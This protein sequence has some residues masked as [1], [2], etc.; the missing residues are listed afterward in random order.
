MTFFSSEFGNDED[1]VEVALVCPVAPLGELNKTKDESDVQPSQERVT[2]KKK[3]TWAKMKR[4]FVSETFQCVVALIILI[5]MLGLVVLSYFYCQICLFGIMI[6]SACMCP[7]ISY[8]NIPLWTSILLI[9]VLG[10]T[11]TQRPFTFIWK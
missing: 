4:N 5:I 1:E 8:F 6:I 3:G 7:F 9:V 10:M 2:E 11:Y